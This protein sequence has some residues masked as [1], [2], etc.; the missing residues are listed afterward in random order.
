VVQVQLDSAW[1][2]GSQAEKR[3][4]ALSPTKGNPMNEA[5]QK[6]CELIGEQDSMR[7]NADIEEL[8]SRYKPMVRDVL[9]VI[10]NPD[11]PEQIV[12]VM[13]DEI[14][15][16]TRAMLD[17]LDVRRLETVEKFLPALLAFQDL[18][19]LVSTTGN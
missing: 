15:F 12:N 4:T 16:Q 13:S 3:I 11:T 9:I 8:V 18:D 19:L 7:L 6:I 5:V 17:R 10:S 2:A 14:Q 1:D